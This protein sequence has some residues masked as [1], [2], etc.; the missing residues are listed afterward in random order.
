MAVAL[1]ATLMPLLLTWLKPLKKPYILYITATALHG[2]RG[3]PYILYIT[4]TAFHGSRGIPYILYIKKP[5][6]S[7]TGFRVPNN[8]LSG[9]VSHRANLTWW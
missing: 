5:V 3:I 9:R 2:S 8:N 6:A 4:A 7:A 1:K